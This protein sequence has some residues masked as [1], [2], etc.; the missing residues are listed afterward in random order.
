MADAYLWFKIVHVIA[1]FAWMAGLFYLPRLFVYHC[2]LAGGSDTDR[3]F[4]VMERRLLKAIMLPAAVVSWV[5]GLLTAWSG[6][7]LMAGQAWLWLKI[8]MV[9]MLTAFHWFLAGV[10]ADFAAGRNVR[11]SKFY[12]VINEAPTVLL[13]GIVILVLAKPFS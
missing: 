7:Y 1:V 13:I 11:S 9:V 2:G 5:F 12:R 6:G 8:G 3:L 4:C 10:Q